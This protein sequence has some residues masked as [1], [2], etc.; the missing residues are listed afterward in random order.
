LEEDY[1]YGILNTKSAKE[2]KGRRVFFENF[3]SEIFLAGFA[4]K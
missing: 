3:E 1:G 2:L 4:L